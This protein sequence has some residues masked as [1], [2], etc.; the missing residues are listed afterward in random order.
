MVREP[1]FIAQHRPVVSYA[2]MVAFLLVSFVSFPGDW[3]FY[4]C[5]LFGFIHLRF[6]IYRSCE[7]EKKK[8]R[9]I[10]IGLGYFGFMAFG[11]LSL[12]FLSMLSHK[13]TATIM[14]ASIL[15]LAT[16]A[17]YAVPAMVLLAVLD[18]QKPESNQPVQTRPTSRPV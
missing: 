16:G 4:T 5:L 18:F 17:L 7:S 10:Q 14:P 13:I 8:R 12:P 15:L 6:E 2:A 9:Y 11:L 3:L 1:Q